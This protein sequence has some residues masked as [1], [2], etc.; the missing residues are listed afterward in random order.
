MQDLRFAFRQL[1]KK[2]AFTAIAVLTLALGIGANTAVFS[3]VNA[4]LLRPLP[5]NRPEQLVQITAD[6]EKLNLTDVG[7]SGLELFDFRDR[8]GVFDEI[9]GLYPI[10]ANL[11]GGDQP[12]RIETLL[13]DVNYFSLLGAK[14][15][16]GRA[17]QPE[18]YHPGIGEATVISDGLWKRRFGG[19][20]GVIGKRVMIDN[21][22][23][24]II[25]VM[26]AGFRHPGR[27]IQ[28]EVEA[29]CPAGWT[30]AP[31]NNPPRGAR[32]LAGAI[33]RLRSGIS[34]EEAQ[35]R[36]NALA[37]ELRKDYPQDY[38]EQAGWSPQVVGLQDGLVGRVRPALLILLIA[39]GLVLLIACAN[40]ANL[41]LV[42]ASARQKEIAIR[43]ALGASRARL[44]R[45]MITESV[46][47]F[48]IGGGLGLAVAVWSVGVFVKLSPANLARLG[49]IGIDAR[50]LI[51]TLAVSLAT[52][53][54]FGLA[55]ALEVSNPDLQET[56]KD[57]GR[58]LAGG[59]R[60]NRLR[61][62]LVVS[63]FALALMLLISAALL[64]RSFRQLNNVDPGFKSQNVLTAR[65]WLP[66]P[67]N[68]EAGPYFRP[69]A[70][71][72]LYR[73]S[74]ERL[75]ALPGVESVGIVN[76]L[77]LGGGRP[78]ATFTVD[79]RPL[80]S[81][82]INT[83]QSFVASPDYFE[84]MGIQLLSGRL[85]AEQDDDRAPSVAVVSKTFAEKFF[86]GE[87]P[88]GKRIR[89]GGAQSNAPWLSVIG[90]VGD[91]KME[92]LD[93]ENKPQLY[94]SIF[95][96]PSVGFAYVVRAKNAASLAGSVR[97]EVRSI[98]ADLPVFSI[99]GMDEVFSEAI[100]QQRFAMSLLGAFAFVALLL[101]SVG[102]YGV[103]SYSVSQRTHEIGIRMTL[104]ADQKD[105]LKL[106]M[107]QGAA[108]TAS[109]MAIG[110]AGAIV[111]TRF[112]KFMLFG[113]SPTD[114]VT[115]AGI[116]VLLGA[117]ALAACYLPA[118]RAT[119]IDPIT[120][121]RYE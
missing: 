84:T 107:R 111:A 3:V 22:P 65:V 81:D 31:F 71:F 63:E 43:K 98:D 25:G 10:N 62:L 53:V 54:I 15:Q 116:T 16:I 6:L 99:R 37:A 46:L 61:N 68:R 56:L 44:I 67:N 106:M 89:F 55:P 14:A 39:V 50:V 113:I 45:Q 90:V 49:D 80:E 85:F 33:A 76:A 32:Q 82:S 4:I 101:S 95:Q 29:W 109:G 91:V 66:Q 27:V 105:V 74:L 7:I 60:R 13:V 72:A 41:L 21:D 100:G 110:I 103:M 58:G 94:R 28:T 86:H 12:E 108:L 47:L 23:C 38:T 18:D 17:L 121:L 42:R 2:P 59:A 117:V 79:G 36:L 97:G 119:R 114:A 30:A 115:F 9:S 26:P 93:A 70:R 69:A 104:G 8:A 75:R 96:V 20:A 40:V 118:R 78:N 51:F 92:S 34:V 1:M 5:F 24:T 120:A 83:A 52:G 64:I 112:M 102:I 11:T 19:D 73:G 88:L 48:L 77:P 87:D 57:A 35:A